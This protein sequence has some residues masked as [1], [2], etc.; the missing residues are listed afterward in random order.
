MKREYIIGN[1]INDWVIISEPFYYNE[2]LRVKLKCKC[3][4]ECD[5]EIRSVNRSNFSNACKGC[6]QLERYKKNGRVYEINDIL[7]NIEIVKIYS[8]KKTTYKVKCLNCGNIYHTGHDTL[9]K[10]KNNKGLPVCRECFDYNKKTKRDFTMCTEH[11]SLSLYKTIERQATLRGIKFNLTPQYLE[12]I[13][14]GKCYLSGL[15]IEIGTYSTRNG[16]KNLGSASLD[17][18]NSSF[19]YIEGNVGWCLKQINI[20]KHESTFEE[21]INTCKIIYKFNK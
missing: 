11:I 21:F 9:N 10:K 5:Y 18:I 15:Q 12:S 13:F 7:M 20:M 3:G 16:Q 19:G 4:R 6:G 8:G 1:K 17:R 2:K 14:T